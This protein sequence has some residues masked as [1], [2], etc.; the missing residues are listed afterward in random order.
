M[1]GSQ[2][3]LLKQ[4]QTKGPQLCQL[5]LELM[6]RFFGWQSIKQVW[7][8][9]ATAHN[10]ICVPI[11]QVLVNKQTVLGVKEDAQRFGCAHYSIRQ[12]I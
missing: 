7:Q 8:L 2:L 4:G 5:A 1:L 9:H 6:L 10:I 3:F 11:P 12:R